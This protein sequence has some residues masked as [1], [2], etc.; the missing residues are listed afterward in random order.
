TSVSL[1]L[2]RISPLL[3]RQRLSKPVS[4]LL[5]P[6]FP[7]LVSHRNSLATSSREQNG[8]IVVSI[9]PTPTRDRKAGASN[10][11]GIFPPSPAI[12]W[13]AR[14]RCCDK[15]YDD[16]ECRGR[17]S[18]SEAPC[19]RARRL[20]RISHPAGQRRPQGP[21]RLPGEDRAAI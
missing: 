9:K 15:G 14:N 8:N 20:V 1:R 16:H 10:G 12:G 2:W 21:A 11:R 3:S 17:N 19:E 13:R 7:S 18:R 6:I 4:Q 5:L